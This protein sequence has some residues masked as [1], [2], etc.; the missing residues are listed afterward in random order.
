[1]L[2]EL[3]LSSN[4]AMKTDIQPIISDREAQQQNWAPYRKVTVIDNFY[5]DPDSVFEWA[6]SLEYSTGEGVHTHFERTDPKLK[7]YSDGVIMGWLEYHMPGMKIDCTTWSEQP[8]Q[9]TFYRPVFP[10]PDIG[11]ATHRHVDYN[12]WTCLISLAKDVPP[13]FGTSLWIHKSGFERVTGTYH[14]I[15][16]KRLSMT[17]EFPPSYDKDWMRLDYI[18]NRYNRAIIYSP[19][20]VHSATYDI[21]NEEL[22]KSRLS[23]IYSWNY[24]ISHIDPELRDY[25]VNVPHGL[26]STLCSTHSDEAIKNL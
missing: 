11:V 7:Y 19:K 13:T 6:Q 2:I 26:P 25:D 4:Q 18:S 20:F 23:Q 22:S 1:M 3:I 17:E 5:P 8:F 10:I 24:D 14:G 21:N 16:G 9:S 15:P 12:D